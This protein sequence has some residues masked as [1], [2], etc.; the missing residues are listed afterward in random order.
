MAGLK[1]TLLGPIYIARAMLTTFKH[2]RKPIV[3]I[4][5]PERQKAVP[6][7]ERGRHILHRYADGL[8][9]CVG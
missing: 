2:N 5:Y 9:K 7:R 3:T 4:E 6:P 8:E 1:D